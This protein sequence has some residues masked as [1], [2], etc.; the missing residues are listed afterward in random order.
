MYVR[1]FTFAVREEYAPQGIHVQHLS[2][3]FVS[4]KMNTFSQKLLDGNLL[5]PDATTYAR[6]AVCT[7][8]RVHTTTG[9]WLH[10]VQVNK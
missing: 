9:Y 1:N 8:G 4:T 5:V 2:P 10:G 7:L 6:S 3:L